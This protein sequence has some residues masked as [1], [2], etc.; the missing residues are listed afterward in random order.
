[1][2]VVRVL[3]VRCVSCVFHSVYIKLCCG[4]PS[5]FNVYIA[6]LFHLF[7]FTSHRK[8][9]H[10]ENIHLSYNFHIK[11]KSNNELEHQF[12]IRRIAKH[13]HT[14]TYGE[15]KAECNICS[16]HRHIFL[17][18]QIKLY[19][20]QAFVTLVASYTL[21]MSCTYNAL[22]INWKHKYRVCVCAVLCTVRTMQYTL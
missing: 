21:P 8:R 22:K 4:A 1:M 14:H 15:Q 12:N 16:T 18:I 2:H 17:I 6:V 3:R 11:V 10:N 9:T 20:N 5:A 13:T 7:L 19:V